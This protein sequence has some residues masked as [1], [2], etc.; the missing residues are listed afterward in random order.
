MS[1]NAE[2]R[3]GVKVNIRRLIGILAA[4]ACIIVISAG[5]VGQGK[6]I[7]QRQITQEEEKRNSFERH[8]RAILNTSYYVY[9]KLAEKQAGKALGLSDTYLEE[10]LSE[11]Q[12]ETE[13]RYADANEL[14]NIAKESLEYTLNLGEYL[15]GSNAIDYG[16]LSKNGVYQGS[17]HD[18][19]IQQSVEQGKINTELE[20]SYPV[21][22]LVSYGEDGEFFLLDSY[23]VESNEVLDTIQS[24][25]LMEEYPGVATKEISNA[26]MLLL[27]DSSAPGIINDYEGGWYNY[28]AYQFA[29]K[30]LGPL[31]LA[32]VGIVVFLAAV[33]MICRLAGAWTRVVVSMPV[34]FTAALFGGAAFMFI[35]MGELSYVLYQGKVTAGIQEALD[36]VMLQSNTRGWDYLFVVAVWVI[37]FGIIYTAALGGLQVFRKGVRRYFMENCLT[38]KV[39]GWIRGGVKKL[40]Q[41]LSEFDIKDESNK[42]VLRIVAVN[43]VFVGIMCSL[44]IFG[45]GVLVL[46]SVL[47]FIGLQ[48]YLNKVKK[49]YTAIQ[50]AVQQMA[51]GKLDVEI[52]EAGMFDSLRGELLRVQDGFAH[53]VD[54]EVKSQNMKTE[55][56]SNVSHDLKTPLT[57]IITYVELLKEESISEQ[58]R[59]EYIETLSQKSLRLKQLIEDLFEVS[60]LNSNNAELQLMQVDLVSLV[61]QMEF[62]YVDALKEKSIEL[63]SR[64]PEGKALL[65]LDSQKTYRVFEN[66]FGNIVKYAMPSTRVYVN[67]EKKE[68]DVVITIR[69][70]SENFLDVDGDMLT[71]RFVRGDVSRNTEGSGLGLAIVKS[72]VEKQGGTLQVI[73]DG[74]LFK[75]VIQFPN[76]EWIEESAFL[77]EVET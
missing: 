37:Y 14:Y 13:D 31:V 42:I 4:M 51:D 8:Y 47:L 73:V 76:A 68:S 57:A 16:I 60:K 29:T 36:A 10:P 69:N 77:Q 19:L 39:L 3:L 12:Y 52:K 75:T 49:D 21:G 26:T 23:G 45:W 33:L 65:M 25:Q 53:A 7:Y 74:D 66:L 5:I 59:K 46:Y 64:L 20:E 38:V 63:K 1:K 61:K 70:T 72:I 62:E 18:R 40:Y 48:K 43:A 35:P 71:E 58:Q 2:S 22:I 6:V 30:G 34:E 28:G 67:L 32:G 11:E 50:S 24:I 56:I 55:L 17:N 9:Q 27:A 15:V 41:Y 44:W 54:Q